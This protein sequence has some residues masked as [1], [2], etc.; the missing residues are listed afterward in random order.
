MEVMAFIFG[1]IGMTFGISG[2]TF[3][4]LTRKRLDKLESKLNDLKTFSS[5]YK[6]SK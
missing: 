1:A 5:E 3:A 2:Y 6:S 4:L